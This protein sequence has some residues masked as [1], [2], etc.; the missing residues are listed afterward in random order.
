MGKGKTGFLRQCKNV[1]VSHVKDL[2]TDVIE[3]GIDSAKE[4]HDVELNVKPKLNDI[5]KQVVEINKEAKE[6]VKATK[7][8]IKEV[9]SQAVTQVVAAVKNNKDDLSTDEDKFLE[10]LELDLDDLDEE[11]QEELGIESFATTFESNELTTVTS[12]GNSEIA[13]AVLLL[14]NSIND[15][16]DFANFMVEHRDSVNELVEGTK[17]LPVDDI[18]TGDKSKLD[19]AIAMVKDIQDKAAVNIGVEEEIMATVVIIEQNPIKYAEFSNERLELI[20]RLGTSV[21][22]LKHNICVEVAKDSEKTNIISVFESKIDQVVSLYNNMTGNK[23]SVHELISNYSRSI[24]G[25]CNPH[26]F[27]IFYLGLCPEKELELCRRI[28][29]TYLKLIKHN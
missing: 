9:L 16:E 15:N 10:S 24:C 14:L 28:Y 8:E 26:L 11:D 25:C 13:A 22:T 6:G 3:K 21:N 29:S 23:L 2:V 1:A 27:N 19:M 7:A 4:L 12:L 17:C 5:V 20:E 18:E